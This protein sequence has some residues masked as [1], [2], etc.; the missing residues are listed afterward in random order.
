MLTSSSG[1][2]VRM[3]RRRPM[4]HKVRLMMVPAMSYPTD[5]R[6]PWI[7]DNGFLRFQIGL[8]RPSLAVVSGIFRGARELSAGKLLPLIIDGRAMR[9]APPAK[10]WTF[11][12]YR[13]SSIAS[14]VA[15]LFSDMTPQEVL[16]YQK[17][18]GSMIPSR[19]F[20]EESEAVSWLRSFGD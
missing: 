6:E 12:I 5:F 20:E 8:K 17:G 1:R 10:A 18:I 11:A 13:L 19:V 14:A 4:G 7:D 2:H 3:R 15:F 16:K 9:M